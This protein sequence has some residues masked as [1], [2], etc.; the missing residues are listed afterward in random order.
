VLEAEIIQG[1]PIEPA[2]IEQIR[3]FL[4][5][6]PDWSRKR[7]SQEL[8]R[9]WNWRNGVGRL[10]DMA[11]RSLLLKLE[12]RG[13]IVL[14]PRRQTPFNRMRDRR[15]PEVPLPLLPAWKGEALAGLGPWMITELSTGTGARQRPLFDHLLHH[16]HYLSHCGTVGENLQ[17]LVT[18]E[19]S[20][21]LACLLFGAAAWQCAERDDYIGWEP[22]QRARNLHLIANN[23]RLLIAP[24]LAAPQLASSVL[25]RVSRRLSRDWQAKYGHPVYLLESFVERD[26][27]S[28]TAYQAANWVQ[29]GQTKG[30]TRQNQPDGTRYDVPVKEVYLYPLHRRFRQQLQGQSVQPSTPSHGH[31]G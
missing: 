2:Q 13:W 29:V 8:A 21:P 12:Q 4:A 11:T 3:Q 19:Q 27:F 20:R 25:S 23:T 17:Y 28:G 24:G 10:K 22:S 15:L 26:R 9:D 1:R 30:R 18:D 5:D 14:P 31:P 7:L 6:H 16:Y